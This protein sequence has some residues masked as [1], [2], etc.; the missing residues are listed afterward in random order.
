MSNKITTEWD[1]R[2]FEKV[3]ELR[4]QEGIEQGK[5]DGIQE[6]VDF[7]DKVN[8]NSK[9]LWALKKHLNRE[10]DDGTKKV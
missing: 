8:P 9:V 4:F 6:C 5:K 10:L 1:V 2:G 3:L 7:L